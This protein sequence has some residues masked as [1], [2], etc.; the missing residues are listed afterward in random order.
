M[1]RLKVL[2]VEDNDFT[3]STVC[4]LLRGDVVV[5]DCNVDS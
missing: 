4:G 3:R 1:G 2:L 5:V